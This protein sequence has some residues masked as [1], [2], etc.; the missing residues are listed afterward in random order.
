MNNPANGDLS[1]STKSQR[2]SALHPVLTRHKVKVA[3]RKQQLTCVFPF[4]HLSPHRNAMQQWNYYVKK[5]PKQQK[6][7]KQYVI[8]LE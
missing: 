5:F 2:V 8:L 1:S 7:H 3:Q 6:A 4:F